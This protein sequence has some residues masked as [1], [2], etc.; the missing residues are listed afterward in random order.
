MSECDQYFDAF[1]L[2][3][4]CDTVKVHWTNVPMLFSKITVAHPVVYVC[5]YENTFLVHI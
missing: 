5:T 2:Y 4:R 1:I 3:S